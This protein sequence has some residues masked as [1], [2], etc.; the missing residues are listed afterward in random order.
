MS[1]YLHT[2]LR[3]SRT[4]GLSR[5]IEG[6]L[7]ASTWDCTSAQTAVPWSLQHMDSES[8]G[9]EVA[10]PQ[11]QGKRAGPEGSLGPSVWWRP[12]VL[13]RPGSHRGVWQREPRPQP[14]VLVG[15]GFLAGC[16]S[17]FYAETHPGAGQLCLTLSYRL[18]WSEIN[19]F[20]RRSIIPLHGKGER[21]SYWL[22]LEKS[23]N[24]W[25]IRCVWHGF[26]AFSASILI[27]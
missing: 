22:M 25:E 14:C 6:P 4:Q 18:S 9:Q 15:P 1:P 8:W 27:R 24:K 21:S 13:S 10:C 5:G 12:E 17:Q 19:Q 20:G 3:R 23:L 26:K 11:S 7:S 2:D 16:H